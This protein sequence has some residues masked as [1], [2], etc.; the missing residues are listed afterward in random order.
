MFKRIIKK[1]VLLV[2]CFA[3]AFSTVSIGTF[4]AS[5]ARIPS[6]AKYYKGNFYYIYNDASSWSDAKAKC[7]QRGGHLAI[8]NN[9]GE[10]AFLYDYAVDSGYNHAYFGISD[11]DE[12]GVW[13]T[14]DGKRAKYTNWR[15]TEPNGGSSENYGQFFFSDDTWNDASFYDQ[16]G[17]ICE[18]YGYSLDVSET[19][20]YLTKGKKKQIEYDIDGNTKYLDSKKPTWKSSNKK[21]AKVSSNG[22]IVA[23][24]A[25]S[26]TVTCKVGSV[27]KSIKVIVKPKAISG[28]KVKSKGKTSVTLS[29]K[30]QTG[31][32]KY[33]IYMYDRDLEEYVSVKT[34]NGNFNKTTIYGL[35]KNKS[36]KFK[37]RGYIT[38]GSKKYYGSYSKKLTVKT[39]K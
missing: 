12:E 30:K 2:L 10:N 37:I 27:K 31:V 33:R 19:K 17:Y 23:I 20:V 22:K 6:Q 34:V 11:A 7:E 35:K 28:F 1:G 25:G 29:W 4:S 14:S 15:S 32:K 18:W 13:R 3:T 9:K 26:C 38:S 5:A 21:V 39:K 36:Y 8:I 16:N 24:N